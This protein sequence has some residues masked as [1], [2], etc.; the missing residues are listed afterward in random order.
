M[1]RGAAL[2][3]FLFLGG[4]DN[5][6]TEPTD[7]D[8]PGLPGFSETEPEPDP[9]PCT[10]YVSNDETQIV[11][12][13]EDNT[14]SVRWNVEFTCVGGDGETDGWVAI[15]ASLYA[16]GRLKSWEHE[17]QIIPTGGSRWVCQIGETRGETEMCRWFASGVLV[18]SFIPNGTPYRWTSNWAQCPYKGPCPEL[19]IP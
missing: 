10:A 18:E 16:G 13:R 4:C 1:M 2:F 6:P 7:P 15:V 11:P 14:Y 12:G 19:D 17:E 3:L 8:A 9:V 5:S